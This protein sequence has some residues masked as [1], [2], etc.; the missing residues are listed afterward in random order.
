MIICLD[1]GHGGEDPG[2]VCK[3]D[4]VTFTE[5]EANLK[6]LLLLRQTLEHMQ[7]NTWV[8]RDTDIRPSW[9]QREKVPNK[10]FLYIA[11]HFNSIGSYPLFYHQQASEAS[12]ALAN[13]ASEFMGI[14]RVWS[15][16]RSRHNGLYI[17]DVKK[18]PA[19][20]WE[21]DAIDD[22]PWDNETKRHEYMLMHAARMAAFIQKEFWGKQY[23]QA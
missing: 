4:G 22:V 15:S 10:A 5:K 1:A 17:D 9:K 20:L 3:E 6:L 13:R 16:S 11:I 14:K 7:F 2:V 18:C 21:V 8:S 19:I 23:A 12:K